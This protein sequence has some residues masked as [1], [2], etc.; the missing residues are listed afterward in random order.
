MPDFGHGPCRIKAPV[1]RDLAVSIIDEGPP[2]SRQRRAQ[3]EA[4]FSAEFRDSC[5]SAFSLC[6]LMRQKWAV[7]YFWPLCLL[8]KQPTYIVPSGPSLDGGNSWAAAGLS[9]VR[10]SRACSSAA[11]YDVKNRGLREDTSKILATNRSKSCTFNW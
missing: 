4:P 9:C 7:R 11:R 8:R 2:V 3:A 1:P 6:P 5:A 10:I